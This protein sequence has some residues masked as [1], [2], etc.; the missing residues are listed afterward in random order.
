MLI[1]NPYRWDKQLPFICLLAWTNPF[2]WI[3]EC[4]K[5]LT[6]WCTCY[7]TN[8]CNGASWNNS[9]REQRC[10]TSGRLS[11]MTSSLFVTVFWI[12]W[13]SYCL[14]CDAYLLMNQT[15]TIIA[16]WTPESSLYQA[17][18]TTVCG[19]AVS[20]FTYLMRLQPWL[21]LYKNILPLRE[22]M[23]LW[24]TYFGMQYLAEN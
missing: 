23:T 2:I 16:Y 13:L 19:L 11:A 6:F 22:C 5:T 3:N 18:P 24:E 7:L 17:F 20:T 9:V 10:Q 21:M 1:E 8:A 12:T 14:L 4:Y 15:N